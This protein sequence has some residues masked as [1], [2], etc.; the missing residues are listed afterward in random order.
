MVCERM[1]GECTDVHALLQS[2]K[3]F[4]HP[5]RT[6]TGFKMRAS[7]AVSSLP[8]ED[9]PGKVDVFLETWEAGSAEP[10][11]A[12]PGEQLPSLDAVRTALKRAQN[13]ALKE[14][15]C[16]KSLLTR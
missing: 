9:Q 13:C 2:D 7:P 5:D 15:C 6:P 14:S 11:H 16:T 3:F 8:A 10:P 1:C 12:H 4:V